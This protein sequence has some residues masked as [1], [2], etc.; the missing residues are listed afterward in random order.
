[1][2]RRG[3]DSLPGSGIWSI[4]EINS[5]SSRI[6]CECSPFRKD[7]KNSV[8]DQQT[9][10]E[11][12]VDFPVTPKLTPLLDPKLSPVKVYVDILIAKEITEIIHRPPYRRLQKLLKP[13]DVIGLEDVTLVEIRDADL[14]VLHS[15]KLAQ[16]GKESLRVYFDTEVVEVPPLQ[17]CGHFEMEDRMLPSGAG[18]LQAQWQTAIL[19]GHRHQMRGLRG[20]LQKTPPSP[21]SEATEE[22]LAV[23]LPLVLKADDAP[24]NHHAEHEN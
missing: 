16:G 4:Q 24:S 14:Q 6:R 21:V 18:L 7:A 9:G 3:G 15:Q 5:F 8:Q 17:I 11:D 13:D 22:L 1:M 23:L 2:R 19:Q 10:A 12:Q 20:S